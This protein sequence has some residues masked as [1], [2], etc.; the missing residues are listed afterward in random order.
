ADGR[1]ARSLMVALPGS[2]R[3]GPLID[4]DLEAGLHL[5]VVGG[6]E[7]AVEGCRRL[8]EAIDEALVVSRLSLDDVTLLIPNQGSAQIAALVAR[9][10]KLLPESVYST[11]ERHGNATGASLPI[12][13]DEALRGGRLAPNDVVV[14]CSFGS[15]FT[16]AW[17]V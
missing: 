16:W 14:L 2:H 6:S 1:F 8:R 5:P 15:G 11:L 10:L 4:A 9:R 3:H 7:V 13:L 12:C 17:A